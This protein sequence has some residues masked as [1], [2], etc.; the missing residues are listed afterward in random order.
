MKT[1]NIRNTDIYIPE[2]NDVNWGSDVTDAF[3]IIADAINDSPTEGEFDT[4]KGFF[5]PYDV[6]PTTIDAIETGTWVTIPDMS[7]DKNE[8]ATVSIK[9]N[10]VRTGG[11]EMDSGDVQLKA[12]YNPASNDWEATCEGFG[13]MEV[14][15]DI[16]S[17]G[18]VQYNANLL[19]SSSF[20]M[21]YSAQATSFN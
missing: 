11:S 20:K 21:T 12:M 3:G 10:Y 8:V 2:N 7:F 1:F 18:V 15:F 17:S 9:I 13:S 14:D 5:G 19:G 4:I 6:K 16:N